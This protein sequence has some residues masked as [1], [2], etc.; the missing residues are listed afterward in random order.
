[1]KY[2]VEFDIDL[3][4]NPYKGAYIALEGIDGSGKTTQVEILRKY[5]EGKGENIVT[6]SEPRKEKSAV[7]RL[8]SKINVPSQSLQYLYTAERIINHK[9]VVEPSLKSGK[10]VLSHRCL[11]SNVPYGLLDRGV[12]NYDSPDAQLINVTQG[13][14]SLYHQF[15]VPDI[16]FYLRVSADTAIKRL[17]HMDKIKEVM[18]E[19]KDKLE[20]IARGY[21]WQLEQFPNEFVIID[22]EKSEEKVF[23]EIKDKAEGIIK[24]K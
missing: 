10:V 17:I 5:L 13:L 19:K 11:W 2:H 7:G 22:G 15:I 6:T 9:D 1:M 16:T 18:Y 8:K 23:Q 20:K 21:E 24:N 12:T 14:M 3:R 4:R